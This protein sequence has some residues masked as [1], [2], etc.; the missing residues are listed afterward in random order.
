MDLPVLKYLD[1]LVGL[2]F[3]MM[4]GCTVVAAV[5]QAITSTFYLRA[6][7][8]RQ[9]LADLLQQLDPTASATDCQY[10]AQLMQRHPLVCRP[11]TLPGEI[12]T[13]IRRK[14]FKGQTWLPSGAPAETVQRHEFVRILLEWSAGQGVLGN[15][16]A[17]HFAEKLRTVLAQ[18][19]VASPAEALSAIEHHTIAQERANPQQPAHIWHTAALVDGC[20][21]NFVGK[22]TGWYDSMALRTSQRFTLQ[23]K[24][25]GGLVALVLVV[26]L[27]LDSCG[28]TE[29]AIYQR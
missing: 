8:L 29:P 19:G 23:S 2:A 1:V 21:S 15:G 20:P 26:A 25:I 22:V 11:A 27:P 10:A 5:T 3:V 12:T 13:M 18:N 28:L 4:L 17:S 14:F 24:L 16:P 7:Y 6:Q 9:G